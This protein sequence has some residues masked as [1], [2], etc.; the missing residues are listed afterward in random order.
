MLIKSVSQISPQ[1]PQTTVV[2]KLGSF[3]K[4]VVLQ[5]LLMLL[6]VV[7]QIDV[8]QGLASFR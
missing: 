2:A 4:V 6:V 5:T 8:G 3:V 1:S 7:E